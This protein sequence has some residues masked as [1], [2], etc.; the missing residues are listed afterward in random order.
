MPC[1]RFANDAINASNA[2]LKGLT[3]AQYDEGERLRIAYEGKLK[4]QHYWLR[5][6]KV[7]NGR[8]YI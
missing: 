7:A 8:P 1:K 6:F 5:L 4:P 2:K 3:Q